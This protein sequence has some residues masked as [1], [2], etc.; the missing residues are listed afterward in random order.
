MIGLDLDAKMATIPPPNHTIT[1]THPVLRGD[2]GC[3][4]GE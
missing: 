1:R 3:Q 2:G 4:V